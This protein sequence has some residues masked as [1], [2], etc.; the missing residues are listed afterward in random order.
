[1]HNKQIK[2]FLRWAGGKQWLA[3]RLSKL[4]QACSGT[5]FE[6]FLGGG[7]VY[8]SAMPRS[9]VLSDLNERLIETYQQLRDTP[10]QLIALL[11]QWNND[12][13]TYY[14][15]REAKSDDAVYRAAQFIFLNRTCWNGLYR[16]NLKG[17]F[18]VPFG[19]HGRPVFD[20]QNLLYTSEALQSAELHH[21][22]FERV[23][24]RAREHDCVYLDP[25]Y[26][27]PHHRNGFHHYNEIRFTWNDQE[28]LA[29]TAASLA[30]RGCCVIVS[31]TD[32]ESVLDL[33]PGFHYQ[34]VHRHSILAASPEYRRPTTELLLTSDDKLSRLID[35]GVAVPA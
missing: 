27:S 30:D 24:A 11:G 5:Y 6:P 10:H 33:Y 12:E 2:P 23:L 29:R 15:I 3:N 19:N 9:A 31:N 14:R 21:A 25:P 18:N 34:R 16:V 8:F 17:Y 32:H 1:M 22:D 4:L 28:R 35:R 7:S 20:K 13:N 26:T